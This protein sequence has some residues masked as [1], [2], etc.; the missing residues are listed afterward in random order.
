MCRARDGERHELTGDNVA[1]VM[2]RGKETRRCRACKRIADQRSREAANRPRPLALEQVQDY[3][4]KLGNPELRMYTSQENDLYEQQVGQA[5]ASLEVTAS[6]EKRLDKM[7]SKHAVLEDVVSATYARL[8][9]YQDEQ[10]RRNPQP[11]V[12]ASPSDEIKF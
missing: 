10:V 6:M 9:A 4:G 8:S 11:A 7:K 5:Q 2:V 12:T 3:I 1:V